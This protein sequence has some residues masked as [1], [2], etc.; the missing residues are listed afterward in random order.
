VTDATAATPTFSAMSLHHRLVIAFVALMPLITFQAILIPTIAV[1]GLSAFGAVAIATAPRGMLG[2]M[3]VS[4]AAI[5]YVGWCLLSVTWVFD[6]TLFVNRSER[7]L[8]PSFLFMA[9]GA[10]VPAKVIVRGFLVGYY[11]MLAYT[12]LAVATSHTAREQTASAVEGAL[13]G[14]HGTFAHKNAM[15]TL[16]VVGVVFI[17]AFETRRRVKWLSL[18][19]IAVLLVGSR[20]G[21]G[22]A[23]L[24]FVLTA[25]NWLVAFLKQRERMS[26]PFVFFSFVGLVVSLIAG[27]GT[28]PI[29]L[30]AYGKDTTFTGRTDIW[31]GVL[32]AI[33]RRPL[34]GYGYSGVWVS[35]SLEPTFTM[36]RHI[37]FRAF[38][39]HNGTLD[40]LLQVGVVGFVLFILF[41]VPMLRGGLRLARRGD[42]VGAVVI[43]AGLAIAVM[44]LSESLFLGPWIPFMCLLRGMTLR[45]EQ[46]RHRRGPVLAP[47]GEDVFTLLSPQ[48]SRSPELPSPA[49]HAV[50]DS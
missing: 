17:M 44:S 34:V 28:L 18:A 46:P 40:V 23:G 22:L 39:A 27:V 30:A 19:T 45:A 2:R 32:W 7:F 8:V 12:V 21:T 35:D 24:I 16:L 1:L 49:L 41:Y 3:R 36:M 42:A 37:G 5:A 20:S 14:W 38:H 6:R 9:I 31:S 11:T 29:V 10:L 15:S 13:P 43:I 50:S 48:S 26:A 47:T 25:W 4:T 33:G